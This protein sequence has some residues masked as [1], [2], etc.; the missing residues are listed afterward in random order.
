MI[1]VVICVLA[2]VVIGAMGLTKKERDDFLNN[3]NR[4]RRLLLAGK[5]R[6]QPKARSMRT[7]RWDS[8]LEKTAQMKAKSCVFAHDKFR[9][10]T[11]SGG[12]K[13]PIYKWIGQN[14]ALFGST[15]SKFDIQQGVRSWWAENRYYNYKTNTCKSGKQCGHYT[16]IAW[17]KT[18][19]LGCAYQKCAKNRRIPMPWVLIVCN[20]APGG[21]IVKMKPY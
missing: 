6:G 13:S 18:T 12:S 4:M 11:P 15:A 9:N 21:N 8:G 16:Q 19:N 1:R 2:I 20:Y 7:M 10:R 17:A 14:L 5:V 3:H